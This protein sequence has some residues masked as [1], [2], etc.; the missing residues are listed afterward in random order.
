M[1]LELC[2]SLQVLVAVDVVVLPSLNILVQ[3]IPVHMFLVEV[4]QQ[5]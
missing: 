3:L 1:M 4:A 5:L 2:Y